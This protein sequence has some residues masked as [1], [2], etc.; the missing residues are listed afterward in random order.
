MRLQSLCSA[1]G[2]VFSCVITQLE[3][4]VKRSIQPAKPNL[5][6]GTLADI[7]R[8]RSELIAENAFLR[9]QLIVLQRQTKR[10]VLIPRDRGVLVLLASRLR[11]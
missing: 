3:Q 9:Q 6:F 11:T 2:Q 10:P 1:I 4:H 5:L 8:S 7:T